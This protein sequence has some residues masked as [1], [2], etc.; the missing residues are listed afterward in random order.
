MR[1]FARENGII[2]YENGDGVCHQ[3]VVENH[4]APH[5]VIIGADRYTCMHGALGAFATGMGST[6][7]AAIMAYGKTWLKVPQ[8]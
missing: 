3:I 7:M 8:S 2:L 5:K 6:D 1:E 4:A